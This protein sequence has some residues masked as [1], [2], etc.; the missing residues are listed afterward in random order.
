MKTNKS[1]D[2]IYRELE[3]FLSFENSS[4]TRLFA[5]Q[6]PEVLEEAL[7]ELRKSLKHSKDVLEYNIQEFEN[8]AQ[9][10]L[11]ESGY[12]TDLSELSKLRSDT[13]YS[14]TERFDLIASGMP[15]KDE[16]PSKVLSARQ[17]LFS[18]KSIRDALTN[19]K[20]EEAVLEMM[21]LIFAVFS[22]NIEDPIGLALQ[23]QAGRRHG[24]QQDKK[25]RGIL[26]AI[27]KVL[28]NNG[29]DMSAEQVWRYFKRNHSTL[30]NQE[31]FD[32]DEYS[33]WL[34]D[35]KLGESE[36]LVQS[37]KGI[38]SSITKK[39]FGRYVA[40]TKISISNPISNP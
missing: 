4:W 38:E 2:K 15:L 21:R 1:R 33:V 39:T 32:V 26:L 8:E 30:K 11:S 10:I 28:Q 5:L 12:S 16:V 19:G 18:G 17:V 7:E 3:E 40:E 31:S 37:E 6:D 20:P 34:Y 13:P 24:G 25:K 27:Q 22:F 29:Q 9:E 35:I 23:H 14:P 36:R